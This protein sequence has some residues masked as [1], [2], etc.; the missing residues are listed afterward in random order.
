MD[1]WILGGWAKGL[2]AME[3]RRIRKLLYLAGI[4]ALAIVLAACGQLPQ[5][6]LLR[7]IERK[8][9]LIG[10]VGTDG[11][12]YTIDQGGANQTAI[13]DD[14]GPAGELAHVYL[15]P[16][17]SPDGRKIAYVKLT[18][19]NQSIESARVFTAALDGEEPHEVYVSDQEIPFY[20]YWSPD[21]QRV[22]FLTS[23]ASGSLLLQM[24]PA[25]GG[26]AQ[27]LDAGT[28]YYWSWSP[29]NQNL[30]VHVGGE[31][32]TQSQERLSF[33]NVEGDVIEES[34]SLRPSEFQTPAWSPDGSR[35]L[36]AAETDD[37]S[38][39]LMLTEP[40]GSA[41]SILKLLDGPTAFAWS[42]DGERVAYIAADS[43][44]PLA[45]GSLTAIDLERPAEGKTT[46]QVDVIG[47]FWSPDSQK[48]AYFTALSDQPTPEADQDDQSGTSTW[49]QLHVLDATN[50]Q[51]RAVIAFLPTEDFTRVMRFFDQYQRSATI[52]SPDSKNLVLSGGMSSA[53]TGPQLGI[54]VV[55]ASG[56]L[57]P[58][59]L[60][61]GDLAFWSWK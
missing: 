28:P 4:T 48:I 44:L 23:A 17:W 54:W 37:G 22:S 35:L 41:I 33:L 51:S 29:D 39:A 42:P 18:G 32:E 15:Y 31:D 34:L 8:S 30:L 47:F 53:E 9:G 24:V 2:W 49:L 14:A 43:G 11:N 40:R 52:W 19:T 21:S 50:G 46:E 45:I 38:P 58:R 16:A 56:N 25:Q 7:T 5:D 61:E 3:K 59:F 55:T 13:T 26:E 36:L 12:I 6:P 57:E 27:V 10:Y 20:L 60:A 1:A